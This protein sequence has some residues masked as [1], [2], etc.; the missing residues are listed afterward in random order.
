NRPRHWDTNPFI[1]VSD[2]FNH[3]RG[4]VNLKPED[5]H[6]FELSHSKFFKKFSL[7]S[8][9]YLRKTN[10]VIQRLRTDPDEH[11]VT[12][13]TPQNLTSSTNSGL[14]LIGRFDL[15]KKWNFI[16]NINMY[17]RNIKGVPVFGIVDND[18][19]SY[20]ANLTNNFT[21]P[22]NIT[23]QIRGEYRSKEIMAQGTRKAMYGIDAGA[24]MDF[25]NKKASLS[26]NIRD[27]FDTR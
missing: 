19:F 14:E 10:D 4:N 16:A 5:V 1:D 7:I 12:L 17:K 18:D 22:S 25:Y 8:S 13:S 15:V 2:P 11:G 21:L 26:L 23:L 9:V 6:V 3:R 27:I 24:K 20:N